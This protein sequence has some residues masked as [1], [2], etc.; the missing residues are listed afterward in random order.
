MTLLQNCLTNKLSIIAM[1]K[2]VIDAAA[3]LGVNLERPLA[4]ICEDAQVNRTQMYE[5]KKQ[6]EDAL[7]RIELPGPG[8]PYQPAAVSPTEKEKEWLL[9][10]QV[11]RYRLDHPGALVAHTNR[12]TY[13]DSYIRFILDLIDEWEGCREQFCEQVDVPY[14]TLCSWIKRD[15]AQPF[16]KQPIRPYFFGTHRVNDLARQIARD[17]SLWEGSLRDFFKYECPRLNVGPTPVR[18]LLIITGQLP[19][20]S[21]KGPRYRDTTTRTLPGSILVTDGKIVT[22]VFS[23]GE[24]RSYNWQGIIDQTTTCHTAVVV[25]DTECAEGVREAFDESVRFLGRPPQALVHD[26]KPIHDD[27]M[28]REHV[29]KTTVMIPAT[30]GRGENKAGM[31]GEFG[32]FAETVD[33]IYMDDK[34][35]DELKKSAVHE[36][37]RA[38]TAGINHAGRAE[39]DGQSRE[40]VLRETCPD[41]E[42]DREFI[43]KLH[44]GHTKARVDIL[45]TKEV[46]RKLL[47]EGF[48]RFGL[49]DSDPKGRIRVWL[50]G[51]YS[52]EAIRQ[53]LAIFGTE[54]EKGRLQNKTAHRYLVKVIQ[55]CQHEIDLRRQE[56][57]L[58]EYAE[59]EQPAWLEELE[60]EHEILVAEAGDLPVKEL[61]FTLADYAV[62]GCMII[63][64]A[65][66][67]NKLKALLENQRDLITAVS[68]HI[69]RLFEATWGNRFALISKLV[70]W[71]FQLA[72]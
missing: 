2:F 64:R 70:N 1:Y 22:A 20:R 40:S 45:P 46:S 54:Q 59:V 42:K 56:E 48:A 41:P 29:E 53:G 51:R 47:D 72:R 43:E 4:G 28:L 49:I 7:E 11:T 55:N 38:Y 13:S 65:F 18:R 3:R 66:W 9:Y 36:V 15:Q 32:K 68:N 61:V 63:Q 10:K 39:F 35:E 25:N 12:T 67:E 33:T 69:R 50:A 44:A 34:N 52:P 31:E 17:Y 37:L 21:P 30:P 62:F 57:L 19:V 6:I 26:N 71:E 23:S 58:R 14:Q 60:K 8:R 16:V 5:H 27:Q 24:I